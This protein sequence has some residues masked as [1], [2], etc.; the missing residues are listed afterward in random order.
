MCV[1]HTVYLIFIGGYVVNTPDLR[2]WIPRAFWMNSKDF[3]DF[4]GL[5]C[6]DNMG[7]GPIERKHM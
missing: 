3:L 5:N 6:V 1:F 4:S 2:L 7:L